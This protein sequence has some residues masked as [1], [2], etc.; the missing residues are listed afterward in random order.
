MNQDFLLFFD[1]LTHKFLL[2][3][4]WFNQHSNVKEYIAKNL[5]YQ[6]F[7]FLEPQFRPCSVLTQFIYLFF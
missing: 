6:A 5:F 4:C 1:Y 3:A 2:C 7:P